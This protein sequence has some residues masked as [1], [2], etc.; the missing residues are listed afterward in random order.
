MAVDVRWWLRSLAIGAGVG[1]GVGLLVGGTLGRVFMRLLF[2]AREDTADLETAMGA[3]IGELTAAGT[4]AVGVFGALVGM[5]FGLGYVAVRRLLPPR[6]WWREAL[7]VLGATGFLL[8]F[9]VRTNLEDFGLL[10]VT[11]SLALT[12]AAIAL[13]AIPVPLLVERLAPDR[14]R[15]FGPPGYAVVGVVLALVVVYAATAVVAAYDVP[16]PP[17]V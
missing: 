7:F 15:S 1:L 13:T 9:V 14:S 10:P 11:L 16:T 6:L 2:L 8:G 3:I 17:W 12:G 4:I 5:T